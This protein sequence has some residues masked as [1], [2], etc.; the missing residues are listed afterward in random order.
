MKF[1]TLEYITKLTNV[2]FINWLNKF[3]N[4]YSYSAFNISTVLMYREFDC[5]VL[6]FPEININPAA[7]SK[8]VP[9]IERHIR[10]I[11]ERS[12][13]IRIKLPYK[14]IPKLM[15]IDLMDFFVVWFNTLSV[16]SGVSST[17]SP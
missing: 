12:H 17:F 4:I 15:V 3:I 8:H 7:T 10:V 5:M 6:Y 13:F 14:R 2:R 16:K 1:I 11:K 9:D